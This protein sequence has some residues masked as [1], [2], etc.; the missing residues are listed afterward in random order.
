MTIVRCVLRTTP[1]FIP[2]MLSGQ[3]SVHVWLD[4]GTETDLFSYYTDELC[5]T[6]E[7]F[8][9]LTVNEAHALFAEKDI[10]YLR[11]P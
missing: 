4:D 10:A 5:F 1:S 3:N 6:A 8:I 11:A 2:G 7:E 9:G